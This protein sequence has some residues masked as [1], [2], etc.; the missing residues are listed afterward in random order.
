MQ[1]YKALPDTLDDFKNYFIEENG[2]LKN[3]NMFKRRILGLTSYFRSAQESLMPRYKKENPAD[4]QI[5]KIPMSDFQFGIY[6]EARVQERNQERKNA[7]KK[8][9]EKAGCHWLVW[10]HDI[11]LPNLFTGFL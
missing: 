8:K 6:E 9:I 2:Q 11:D 4:F 5:I 3:M 7:M 10:K 1:D